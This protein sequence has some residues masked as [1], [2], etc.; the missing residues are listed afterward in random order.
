MKKKFVTF[1]SVL[2]LLLCIPFHVHAYEVNN[3]TFD[4]NAVY[5]AGYGTWTNV[6]VMSFDAPTNVTTYIKQD[7]NA[8][9]DVEDGLGFE[10]SVFLGLTSYVPESGLGDNISSLIPNTH[11]L[12]L[13]AENLSGTINNV[14]GS[15]P[16]A[17]WDY[18]FDTGTGLDAIGLYL[19][20]DAE[21]SDLS[22]N[23][24]VDG[25]TGGDALNVFSDKI[26]ELAL[27]D[28]SG[29]SSVTLDGGSFQ[30][31]GTFSVSF[32]ITDVTPG[33]FT[34]NLSGLAFEDIIA[35]GL[36][37]LFADQT[38]EPALGDPVFF[39]P[40]GN[41]IPNYFTTEGITGDKFNVSSTVVPEP[42]TLVL[43]GTGLLGLAGLG[44]KKFLKKS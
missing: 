8:A 5:G 35:D 15:L 39:D 16:D 4:M 28:P 23:F 2:T 32:E 14:A 22:D 18:T 44:R 11:N 30:G 1:L 12:I 24:G 3:Y 9:G 17:E 41:D 7:L 40:D 33:I 43:F 13:V 21:L 25:Y 31:Q 37:L 34:D 36:R 42:A 27:V 20:T 6:D 29:G 10:E 38:G 19:M 26:M